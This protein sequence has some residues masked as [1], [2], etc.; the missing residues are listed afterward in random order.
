[1]TQKLLSKPP[2]RYL[3]DIFTATQAAT[4]FGQGLYSDAELD[5]KA[6]TDKEG[7]MNFLSKLITLVELCI[8]EEIDVKP[9]KVV[10]GHE[11]EKT[12]YFLQCLFKAA[13]T[14][15]ENSGPYV[16]RVLGEDAG[17]DGQQEQENAEM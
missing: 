10:A 17:D 7:K 14:I 8:E 11:P 3:H 6:I 12:N 4:G 13:T 5:A 2:F 1:M 15:G 9:Q 16:A